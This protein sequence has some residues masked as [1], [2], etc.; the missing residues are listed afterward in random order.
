MAV[1]VVEGLTALV[2]TAIV[3]MLAMKKEK[4][5]GQKKR[6]LSFS[7]FN[8]IAGT[9]PPES[10]VCPP[11]MSNLLLM[12]KC[13]T[14]DALRKGICRLF[15]YDRFRSRV[16]RNPSTGQWEHEKLTDEQ[17]AD[18]AFLDNFIVQ[19]I[20][21]NEAEMLA[22]ANEVCVRELEGGYDQLPPFR[23][24]RFENKNGSNG[25]L[26][27]V[28][29]RIHHVIG[30]G[31]SLV[32]AM[33]Q[34]FFEEDGRSVILDFIPKK[35]GGDGKTT[36]KSTKSGGGEKAPKTS[37]LTSISLAIKF[38]ICFVQ[39][40]LI[41]ASSF[42][43]D[44]KFT[45]PKKASLVMT[46]TRQVVYFPTVKLAIIKAIKNAAGV[47]LNDVM[48]SVTSGA[49]ARYC[50]HMKDPL[51]S[52]SQMLQNRALVP[53]AFPRTEQQTFDPV[54][55]LRNYWAFLSI[56]LPIVLG[57]EGDESSSATAIRRLKTCNATTNALKTSPMAFATLW[58]QNNLL[59]LLPTFAA[60]KAAYDLFVRHTMVF[61]N[62]PGPSRT[63]TFCGSR[64]VGMQA[65]FPN[66]I[67]QVIMI[68]Y[69]GA[70]FNNM[71]LDDE[72]VGDSHLLKQFY[73]EEILELCKAYNVSLPSSPTHSGS[74]SAVSNSPMDVLLAPLSRE[75]TCGVIDVPAAVQASNE[76]LQKNPVE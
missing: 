30:D 18:P 74:G 22:V 27:G 17:I 49:I 2:A 55:G 67:P 13:P 37:L 73:L 51:M 28:L 11:I 4:K 40:A 8:L 33:S 15:Y 72:L 14:T 5:G 39:A 53:F 36:S 16:I 52:S 60:Q 42:D 70:L 68:S 45:S 54:S 58:I 47:T 10:K 63:V 64:I 34:V 19:H 61:S 24:H 48:L 31:M 57:R 66:L 25:G 26:H 12:D 69:A 38:V 3:Y 41:A 76:Y 1:P 20:V 43:S 50:R 65:I 9:F 75:N 44:I 21:N 62:V 29:L 35:G 6:R 71:V 46:P 32:G 56:P 23:L 7:S 59:P